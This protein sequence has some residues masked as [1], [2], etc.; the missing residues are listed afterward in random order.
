MLSIAAIA[1]SPVEDDE[2]EESDGDFVLVKS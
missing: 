2:D 1:I